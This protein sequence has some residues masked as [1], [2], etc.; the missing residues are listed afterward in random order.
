MKNIYVDLYDKGEYEP[1]GFTIEDVDDAEYDDGAYEEAEIA[2]YEE[3]VYLE[4]MY[5]HSIDKDEWIESWVKEH[6]F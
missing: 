4:A 2:W 1:E 5:D 6:I 3:G